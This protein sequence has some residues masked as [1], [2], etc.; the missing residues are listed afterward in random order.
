MHIKANFASAMMEIAFAVLCVDIESA[1]GDL[2]RGALALF[3][4]NDDVRAKSSQT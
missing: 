1:V 3:K 4:A 2:A